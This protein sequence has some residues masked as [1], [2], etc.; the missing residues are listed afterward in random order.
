MAAEQEMC[1]A[2]NTV[3]VGVTMKTHAARCT[4]KIRKIK[5]NGE[6]ISLTPTSEGKYACYCDIPGGCRGKYTDPSSVLRHLKDSSSQWIGEEEHNVRT[7]D[8]LSH[9]LA[10]HISAT[11]KY[12]L[13]YGC[14]SA[15]GPSSRATT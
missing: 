9:V 1:T 14:R 7:S 13:T 15:H 11:V 6:Y 2:C 10:H 4:A 12:W 5:Y 8:C 3:V